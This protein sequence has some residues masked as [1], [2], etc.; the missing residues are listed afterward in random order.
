MSVRKLQR[1]NNEQ[2]QT[3]IL[4]GFCLL[5]IISFAALAIDVTTLYVAHNQ[6]QQAADAAALAGAQAFAAT[7]YTSGFVTQTV[8]QTAASQQASAAGQHESV[9][10]RNLQPS[11]ITVSFPTSTADNP[12]VSVTISRTGVPTFFAKIWGVRST[13]VTASAKAEAYNP[14][15][16]GAASPNVQVINPKPFALPNCNPNNTST[17]G[18]GPCQDSLG[19]QKFFDDTNHYSIVSPST[20]VGQS[21]YVTELDN[22]TRPAALTYYAIDLPVS[23]SSVS[24]PSTN[25]VSCDSVNASTPGYYETIACTNSVQLKCGQT[26]TV[27][28]ATGSLHATSNQAAM[29][30]V[31]A[32]NYGFGNGQDIF[33]AT[34]AACSFPIQ[35]DGGGSNPDASLK[36]VNNISRSDSIVTLPVWDGTNLCPGGTCGTG[37]VIGFLQVAIR[38]VR[39]PANV[40]PHGGLG[41]MILNAVG[42]GD[43]PST[44]VSGG[45]ASPVPVRLVQS[46]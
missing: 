35:I 6:A 14:S 3:I 20:V 22:V 39:N 26:F 25:Q 45:T 36:N 13:T 23:P 15:G 17:P 12:L 27:D 28:P 18:T 37:T 21:F 9:G 5:A 8:A 2:G 1:R 46:P 16:L 43:A 11:E 40:P 19:S 7:G 10:G 4:V 44:A 41:L 42:C 30:L 29:C 31:H 34:N 38:R 33:C 24:C 32:S